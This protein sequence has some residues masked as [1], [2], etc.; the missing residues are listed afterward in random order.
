MKI[1]DRNG[2]EKPRSRPVILDRSDIWL[3]KWRSQQTSWISGKTEPHLEGAKLK[4]CVLGKDHF[5]AIR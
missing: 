5:P 4:M 2:L 1:I 3:E